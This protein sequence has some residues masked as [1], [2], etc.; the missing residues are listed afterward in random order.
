MSQPDHFTRF[1][2]LAFDRT[3]DG[4]LTMRFHTSDG[5]VTFTGQT[6]EDLPRA[7]EGLT[8]ADLAYQR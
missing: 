1:E 3:D 8:A 5:P 7:L 6:R 4:V 2:N